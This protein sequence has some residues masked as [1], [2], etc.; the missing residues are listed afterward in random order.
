MLNIFLGYEQANRY[1]IYDAENAYPVGYIL[2]E[3]QGIGTSLMR[4]FFGTHRPFSATIMTLDGNI[5][6]KLKRPYQFI[7]SRLFVMNEH[8]EVIGE[9][10]QRWHL[11]RRRYDLFVDK[12]Q[13]AAIDAPWLSWDFI[14]NDEEGRALACVNKNFV[15]FGREIFTDTSQYIIRMGNIASSMISSSGVPLIEDSLKKLT[16]D[17]RAVALAAAISIDFDYFS[18]HSGHGGIPL[19]YLFPFGGWGG[20]D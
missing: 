11:W 1:V 3:G 13:F 8:E 15:G 6:L 17:E 9:V 4:Q 2:E 12:R 19:L 14:M 16:V 10:Q 18:R 7:N 20:G 5:L